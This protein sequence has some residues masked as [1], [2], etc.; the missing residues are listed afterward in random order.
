MKMISN[1]KNSA[2]F[3]VEQDDLSGSAGSADEKPD[4]KRMSE[5]EKRLARLKK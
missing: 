1:V 4:E 5:E 3:I 2:Y